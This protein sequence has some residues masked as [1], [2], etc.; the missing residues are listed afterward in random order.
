MS[1]TFAVMYSY[2]DDS[3]LREA[4]RAVH[5]EYLSALGDGTLL[6]AGAWAPTEAPGGLLIFRAEERAAVERIVAEDPYTTAG[7]VATADIREWA[8]PL[9]PLSGQLNGTA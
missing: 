3:A 4:T 8:P 5:R 7:V 9:G 6:V 1:K 2:T